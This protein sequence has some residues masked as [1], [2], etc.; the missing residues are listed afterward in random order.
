V[1]GAER[2]ILGP[3]AKNSVS[4]K[5]VVMLAV[6]AAAVAFLAFTGPGQKLHAKLHMIGQVIATY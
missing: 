2:S 4:Q 1:Y 3:S 6:I 5:P